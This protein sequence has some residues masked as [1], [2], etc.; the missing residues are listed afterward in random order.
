M[1]FGDRANGVTENS[2]PASGGFG[3]RATG[4]GTTAP[5]KKTSMFGEVLHDVGTVLKWSPPGIAAQVGFNLSKDASQLYQVPMG[6]YAQGK[7]IVHDA[8]IPVSMLGGIRA[9]QSGGITSSRK[10]ESQIKEMAKEMGYQYKNYYYNR[11][12]LK[13][14]WNHPLQATLDALTVATIGGG[15][16]A[17]LA[18]AG[19]L[20]AAAK[21]AEWGKAGVRTFETSA[22]QVTKPTS[23]NPSTR[24][25][26]NLRHSSVI[27]ATNAIERK[28]GEK[29]Y[30]Q[31]NR[32]LKVLQ[33]KQDRLT[34]TILNRDLSPFDKA[35]RGLT[36][37][38]EVAI[39]L[40][41]Q[42]YHPD[43]YR[44][45][46]EGQRVIAQA[47][48]DRAVEAQDVNAIT[49]AETIVRAHDRMLGFLDKVS[50]ELYESITTT[51]KY[52]NAYQAA[53]TLMDKSAEVGMNLNIL[54]A[55]DVAARPYLA[56]RVLGGARY[57]PYEQI[58][59][60][61][62]QA[63]PAR[64]SMIEELGKMENANPDDV[65]DFLNYV[66]NTISNNAAALGGTAD[67]IIA[68]TNAMYSDV[69]F[70]VLESQFVP[71]EAYDGSGA[72]TQ[73][74]GLFDA[75][76]PVEKAK[77]ESTFSRDDLVK[78]NQGDL[79]D[80]IDAAGIAQ[81][82]R[83]SGLPLPD[84]L[85]APGALER[86]IADIY[87]NAKAGTPG[88]FWYDT[89]AAIA[90]DISEND[91]AAVKMGVTP[92][93]IAQMIAVFSQSADTVANMAFL[94]KA[95]DQWAE[96]KTVYA[97]MFPERQ[98]PEIL[99][100]L[101][102]KPWEGRK[103]SSFYMNTIE[104][105]DP[106]E[107]AR[108][109]EQ[110][111]AEGI[112]TPGKHPVTVDRWVTRWFVPG[113]DVPGRFYDSFE[114]VI[115]D[116]ADQIGW[117]PK[118]LQAAAWVTSKT[119]SLAE[120]RPNASLAQIEKSGK[121][122]YDVGFERYFGRDQGQLDTATRTIHP[123]ADRAANLANR[124][125]GGGTLDG[126]SLKQRNYTS[127][128]MAS[129]GRFE[130]T[131]GAPIKGSH[132]EEFRRDHEAVL[133]GDRRNHIGLW[134][135]P[136]DG[137]VYFDISRRFT[138]REQALAWGR[139]QGQLTVG[140]M[141]GIDRLNKIPKSK[142]TDADYD[143]AFP[144]T[145]LTKTE[146]DTIKARLRDEHFGPRG[147]LPTPVK[148]AALTPNPTSAAEQLQAIMVRVAQEKYGAGAKPTIPQLD[149]AAKFLDQLE[150]SRP[151]DATV[152]ALRDLR[153]R[154]EAEVAP[155]NP[156]ILFQ[157]EKVTPESPLEARIKEQIDQGNTSAEDIGNILKHQDIRHFG[158]YDSRSM[159]DQVESD[160]IHYAQE[161]LD[162][163]DGLTQEVAAGTPGRPLVDLP[164]AGGKGR[165]A[166][167]AQRMAAKNAEESGIPYDPPGTYVEADSVRGA[168]IGDEYD[169]MLDMNDPAAS[170][171]YKAEVQES[172]NALID[173][174]MP[175]YQTIVD[176]GYE[177]EFYPE[178]KSPY[179]SPWDAMQD[180][181]HNKHLYI[182]PTEEG[183]GTLSAA[184]RAHPMLQ[185]SGVVWKGRKV[186]YNDI[187]RA[188]HDFFG[189]YKEGVGFRADG[190]ENAWRSHSAMY[191]DIARKAMTSETRGQNSWVN[192]GTHAKKNAG[193]SEADTIYA[194]QKAGIMPDWVVNEG[195]KDAVQAAPQARGVYIPGTENRPARIVLGQ[196]AATDTLVHEWGHHVSAVMK[197][198]P[199][200]RYFATKMGAK[201]DKATGEYVWPREAEEN[202]A[203][204]YM[205]WARDQK[206]AV[207][208]A[209]RDQY[210]QKD[211]PELDPVMRDTFARMMRT[212]ALPD[213][214][215]V[216]GPT[217]EELSQTLT[218]LIP[219]PHI[220]ESLSP[221][222]NLAQRGAGANPP[223]K[224]ELTRMNKGY[225]LLTSQ[226]LPHPSAWRTSYV[227]VMGYAAAIQRHD[228]AFTI[229]RDLGPGLEKNPDWYYVREGTTAPTRAQREAN[230]L[231]DNFNEF[232]QK[233]GGDLESYV[234]NNA[235]SQEVSIA[236]QWEEEG[237]RVRQISPKEHKTIF[238][239][240]KQVNHMVKQWIDRPTNVWRTMTLTYRPAWVVNN[241]VGQTLLYAMNHS[242]KG[243][244]KAYGQAMIEEIRRDNSLP[245][246]LRM[247]GLF[248]N[249]AP[250]IKQAFNR[251]ARAEHKVRSGIQ[252]FNTAA[253]DSIPRNATYK[254]II[255]KMSK[256]NEKAAE[257]SK[258]IKE[259][260]GNTEKLP[261]HLR[262]LHDSIIQEVLDELIDFGNLS[263]FERRYIRRFVPFY[264]WIK[265]ITKATGHLAFE[266]P[267][268][269]LV[270]YHLSQ[271]GQLESERRFGEGSS[272]LKGFV[273]FG[274]EKDGLQAGVSTG[275]LNPWATTAQM[276]DLARGT[277]GLG[278]PDSPSDNAIFQTNF[279]LQSA[280]QALAGVDPFSKKQN[281]SGAAVEFLKGLGTS[282]PEYDLI[283]GLISPQDG[284]RKLTPQRRSDLIARYAGIN[285]THKRPAVAR[286][287]AK[288]AAGK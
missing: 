227:K 20:G 246:E 160:Y 146:A 210:R 139:E 35:F 224:P 92:S 251:M 249:E 193:A 60:D 170:S 23:A 209:L 252:R 10:S 121:D 222:V 112:S 98:G 274:K 105:I 103:R 113:T 77:G 230:S 245:D 270:L 31:N 91:R 236:K 281:P 133:K 32:G 84:E 53:K 271:Q 134:H 19:K 250:A 287:L 276:S 229:G 168:R 196:D 267:A 173:E 221:N 120:K 269:A 241:F 64:R 102:G 38:E 81:R 201:F 137:M 59:Y 234:K 256:T 149:S 169:K 223:L 117:E 129:D 266:H 114:R 215:F 254:A 33:K 125:G 131:T 156:E 171:A 42:G 263:D 268:R 207:G 128:Y 275:G 66:D 219:F 285:I 167:D 108:L 264:S 44:P 70:K 155:P 163:G 83:D 25:L 286:S 197:G 161:Q 26:Q 180:L 141:K 4:G 220:G 127:G 79:P 85:M 175:Q 217:V 144:A 214:K 179:N 204:L 65:D 213:G 157:K 74:E 231:I 244:L 248:A 55:E 122:A 124:V 86:A 88:R 39:S 67:E 182:F 247:D 202:F 107:Y 172:Y 46:V 50:P 96:H 164:D 205:Q 12:V 277:F 195:R 135:N 265:G 260:R 15:A 58:A 200:E 235:S 73:Q 153:D 272:I 150:Q 132:V 136:D 257:L 258:F 27:R 232:E 62:L 240:F 110:R 51:P 237:F 288:K 189:H 24:Y 109:M 147:Y 94:R 206:G 71:R 166:P 14:I 82:A 192:F 212:K 75:G 218:D 11:S 95:L 226:W 177:I 118:E 76:D 186:T 211:L 30:G 238:G 203:N 43:L 216:G 194:D 119:L 16:A 181:R 1:A 184:Q 162:K 243:G 93:Q 72:L 154:A 111:V 282:T 47:K 29:G 185:D 57:T 5:K 176:G 18:T 242:F 63:N 273:P 52:A 89:A 61:A 13:N 191:S 2:K 261:G 115:Q 68:R 97:G 78:R 239:E 100:I 56:A 8:Q 142:R 190:E 159:A 80:T 284:P 145:G 228:F 69:E 130:Q 262:E 183:F 49:S 7:A 90:K 36:G 45:M 116:M 283:K 152:Q 178:G 233:D 140:D 148:G 199:S 106:A 253:S 123:D 138:S 101:Q 9:S 34:K 28:W 278:S 48:L 143:R 208:N 280:V 259:N 104:K 54:R 174:T 126:K 279:I 40:R 21:E 37:P 158:E 87:E 188:V 6:L 225:R 22:G 3:A 17:K 151:G 99:N 165:P 255:N 198:R 41:A 187:F